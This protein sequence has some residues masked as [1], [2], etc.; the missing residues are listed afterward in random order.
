MEKKS[1]RARESIITEFDNLANPIVCQVSSQFAIWEP[2]SQTV[3]FAYKVWFS[4]RSKFKMPNVWRGFHLGFVFHGGLEAATSLCFSS[5]R[6]ASQPWASTVFSTF[7]IQY[8]SFFHI[9]TRNHGKV[10]KVEKVMTNT[11]HEQW[12]KMWHWS[13]CICKTMPSKKNIFNCTQIMI[14]I[15]IIF[16][17]KF[18]YC[19]HPSLK[20]PKSVL[21]IPDS[22]FF[23]LR[24][25][26]SS[27][28]FRWLLRGFSW[29]LQWCFSCFQLCMFSVRFQYNFVW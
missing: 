17:T 9:P 15:L 3:G 28:S 29:S 11:K 26:M 16:L 8:S 7:N 24:V 19:I 5:L 18:W 13:Q 10:E 12:I 21:E 1:S 6:I 27:Q 14:N 25:P 23:S 20:K 4:L 2:A 22:M